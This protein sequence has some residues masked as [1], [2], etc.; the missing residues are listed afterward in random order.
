MVKQKYFFYNFIIYYNFSSHW[1]SPFKC[2]YNII[3]LISS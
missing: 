2:I 3:F 1:I